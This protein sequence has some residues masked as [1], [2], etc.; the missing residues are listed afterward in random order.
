MYGS[1]DFG[2]TV[3]TCD[4]YVEL[5]ICSSLCLTFDLFI[6]IKFF[7]IIVHVVGKL[8]H[9]PSCLVYDVIFNKFEFFSSATKDCS[10]IENLPS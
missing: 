7:G 4:K 1:I 6:N 8:V 3:V 5:V 9:K 10:T 2:K